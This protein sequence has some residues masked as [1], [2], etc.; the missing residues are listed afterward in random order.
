MADRERKWSAFM[1][2][3]DWQRVRSETEADGPIVSRVINRFLA[4]TA[5]SPLP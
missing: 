3:A 2:D 4:P 1:A 5:Y